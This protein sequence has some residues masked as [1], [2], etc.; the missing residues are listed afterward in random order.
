GQEPP[1]HRWPDPPLRPRLRPAPA[2]PAGRRRAASSRSCAPD[3][4]LFA[5]PWLS[6]L[7]IKPS[8]SQSYDR[9]SLAGSA[10]SP[11]PAVGAAGLAGRPRIESGGGLGDHI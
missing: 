10:P 4:P 11:G 5:G 1:P 2:P 3:T 6:T 8:L 9:R 7:C